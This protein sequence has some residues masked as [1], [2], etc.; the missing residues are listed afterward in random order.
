MLYFETESHCSF[1]TNSHCIF[2]T[3]S[4]CISRL[5][6]TVFLD[7]TMSVFVSFTQWTIRDQK[8]HSGQRTEVHSQF[9]V[10]DRQ[11]GDGLRQEWY[12]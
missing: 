7:R 6:H 5:N 11:Y 9:D 2:E 4:Y 10:E 12:L 8:L 3:E 1:E